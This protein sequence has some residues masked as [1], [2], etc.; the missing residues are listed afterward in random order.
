MSKLTDCTL[1]NY[2]DSNIF[3]QDSIRPMTCIAKL[4]CTKTTFVRVT[5]ASDINDGHF[6]SFSLNGSKP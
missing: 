3:I 5:S 1:G 4:S 6:L 2:K